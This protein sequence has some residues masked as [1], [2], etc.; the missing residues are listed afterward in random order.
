MDRINIRLFGLAFAITGA[1]YYV[2][3]MIVLA[4][5]SREGAIA[6]FNSILHGI[7][8]T[9]IIRTSMPAWEMVIGIVEVFV[10]SWFAGAIIASIYNYGLELKRRR[11]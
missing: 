10:L 4:T 11:T 1:L 7:D 5:T 9:N 6:F 3:C 8:V 2:G